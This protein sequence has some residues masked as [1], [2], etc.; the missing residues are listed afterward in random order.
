[1][2]DFR[3]EPTGF[4]NKIMLVGINPG[5]KVM[6]V[7]DIWNTDYGKFIEQML[8]LSGLTRNDVWMTNLYK[9]K[10]DKNRPLT[11]D[12]IYMGRAELVRE[13]FDVDPKVIVLMGSVVI[14]QFGGKLNDIT[15]WNNYPILSINHPSFARRFWSEVSDKYIVNFKKI[16]TLYGQIGNDIRKTN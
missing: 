15:Y 16:K 9:Y 8:A 6:E 10:T 14:K 7:Q 13:I 11:D 2:F 5:F 4:K 12:E 3:V 1:M